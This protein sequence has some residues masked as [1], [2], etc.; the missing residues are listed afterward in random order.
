MQAWEVTVIWSGMVFVFNSGHGQGV[1][2]F[3]VGFVG[4]VGVRG[5][6]DQEYSNWW[7]HELGCR[8]GGVRCGGACVVGSATEA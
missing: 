1:I 7:G 6:A 8:C 3:H 5:M 2:Q 4:N